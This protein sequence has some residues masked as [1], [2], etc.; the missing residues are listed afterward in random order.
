[1]ALCEIRENSWKSAS[2]KNS[3]IHVL[4]VIWTVAVTLA[5][6]KERIESVYV[7]VVQKVALSAAFS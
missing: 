6:L 4:G 7:W 5:S 2:D 1:V 3:D